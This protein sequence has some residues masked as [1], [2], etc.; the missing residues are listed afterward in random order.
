MLSVSLMLPVPPAVFPVA[1]PAATDVQVA[2]VIAAGKVS[3]TV[4]PVTALGPL[5][6]TTSV[7]VVVPPGVITAL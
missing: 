3:V 6:L 5:F 7:K 4:A 2:L 1:P